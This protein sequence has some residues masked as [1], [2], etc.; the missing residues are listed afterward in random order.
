[1]QVTRIVHDLYDTD[2]KR[3]FYG[4]GGIDARIGPLPLAWSLFARTAG[5]TWGA[6]FK[7]LL[8]ALP[9]AMIVAG[10]G[11][12]LPL[13]TNRVD[14]DPELK[15]AW[16]LPALRVTYKDHPDDLAMARFLQDRGSRSC[17][18][19]ARSRLEGPGHRTDRAARTCSARAAWATIQH[20]GRRQVPS[21]SR[22]PQ[23][24][25]VRRLELRDVGARPADDDDPG[26]RLPRRRPHRAVRAPGEL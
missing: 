9:R 13:E 15:D 26:A 19:R 18:R 17:R 22:R 14:L 8:E 2:P 11:T 3:G 7:S 20:L 4:G 23:S 6:G 25:R 16:G 21:Q 24:V 10:H 12:S 5:P 1:M